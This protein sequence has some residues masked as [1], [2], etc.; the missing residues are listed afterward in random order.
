[1]HR[2]TL[3]ESSVLRA[4]SRP[5]AA[6]AAHQQTEQLSKTNRRMNP[7]LFQLSKTSTL[8]LN[9]RSLVQLPVPPSVRARSHGS[10]TPS[11]PSW[12]ASTGSPTSS[13]TS[14]AWAGVGGFPVLHLLPA[15]S[16]NNSTPIP[17]HPFPQPLPLTKRTSDSTERGNR[18]RA[19]KPY[20]T[21]YALL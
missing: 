9:E 6:T 16:S 5:Y 18:K 19:A 13:A 14:E 2:Q 7:W 8:P 4:P 21:P 12:N 11:H 1:M 10:T 3:P 20:H 15:G 17:V